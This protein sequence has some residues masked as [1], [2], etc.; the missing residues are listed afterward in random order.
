MVRKDVASS[1]ESIFTI[2]GARALD[3][4]NHLS[5][6]PKGMYIINGRKMAVR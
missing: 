6:L 1:S 4:A 2:Q 5:Q 3:D